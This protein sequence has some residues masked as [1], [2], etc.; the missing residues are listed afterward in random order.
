MTQ[1]CMQNRG[2][3]HFAGTKLVTLDNRYVEI[4]IR[5]RTNSNMHRNT[6]IFW[7]SDTHTHTQEQVSPLKKKS[8]NVYEKSLNL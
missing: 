4:Y 6:E 7:D 3:V 1:N 2:I 5:G 8:H